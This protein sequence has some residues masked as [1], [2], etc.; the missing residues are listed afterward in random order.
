MNIEDKRK[1]HREYQRKRRLRNSPKEREY[2]KKYRDNNKDKRK[3]VMLKLRFNLT[4]EE[5]NL[6]LDAQGGVCKICGMPETTRKNNSDEVRML[7]VDHDHNTGKVRGLLCNK[8]NRSLG[9]YE[10]TKPRAEEFEKYLEEAI[11][12]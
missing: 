11:K 1:Y 7:C 10:A 4:L 3:N 5:Y 6:M 8:C 2:Q 9:H 12:L